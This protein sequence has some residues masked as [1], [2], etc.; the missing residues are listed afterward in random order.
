MNSIVISPFWQSVDEQWIGA[1]LVVVS[2]ACLISTAVFTARY[3]HA[4]FFLI[5]SGFVF[6]A[7]L[8]L[9]PMADARSPRLFQLWLMSPQTLTGLSLVQILLTILSVFGSVR[10]EVNRRYSA[11]FLYK[12]RGWAVAGLAVLP[13]PVLLVCMFW[14]E[15]NMMISTRE[16]MP[17]VIGLKVAVC[18]TAIIAL[19]AF[20]VSWLDRYRLL[21]L[22]V[23]TGLF[24]LLSGALL[25]CLTVKLSMEAES[26]TYTPNGFVLGGILVVMAVV[27][28][29]GVF[30]QRFFR[31][32][33][34][35]G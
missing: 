31:T 18:A 2:F 5:A 9:A 12:L 16:E 10:Q 8:I 1:T 27:M 23:F 30:R 26:S 11:R 13:S 17:V 28:L 19:S 7:A 20:V 24:L 34:R 33:K 32:G 15:Q 3:R 22:H 4:G 25:P 35:G 6:L 14:V 29:F 21:S